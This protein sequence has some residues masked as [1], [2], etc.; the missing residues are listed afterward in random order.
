MKIHL[1]FD[2]TPEEFRKIIGLPEVGFINENLLTQMQNILKSGAEGFEPL[3]F[4]TPLV[5]QSID[6]FTLMQNLMLQSVE[7]YS[8][9]AKNFKTN[10]EENVGPEKNQE[11]KANSEIEKT[12]DDAKLNK[13]EDLENSKIQKNI[14]TKKAHAKSDKV[15]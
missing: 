8:K 3:S 15:N 7:N 13:K 12:N 5:S 6:N 11:T 1:E 9:N 2:M 4:L 14:E 10:E